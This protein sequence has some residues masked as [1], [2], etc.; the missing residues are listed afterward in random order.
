MAES[1][2]KEKSVGIIILNYK[3][4]TE[5]EE[6]VKSVLKQE[7]SNYHILIVDNGSDNESYGYLK[8]IYQK[9]TKVS[10]IKARKNYGFAKGNNIGIH[11]IKEKYNS[12]YV[13]LLN[14]DVLLVDPYYIQKMIDSDGTNIGVIGSKIMQ[15][16]ERKRTVL[17]K[18]YRYVS[19]P[20][21][22]IYYGRLIAKCRNAYILLDMIDNILKKC[23]GDYI[24]QGCVLLLTPQY[25]Q[26]YKGLDA[27]TFLYCEE[28]LLFLRCRRV[29]LKEKMVE[30][31]TIL[32]KGKQSSLELYDNCG[33]QFFKYLRVSY[34]YVVLESIRN[35]FHQK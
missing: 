16:G 20:G 11:Y 15:C 35:M 13:L 31:L 7:Y 23:K 3:N 25:F 33:K 30:N 6:C 22:M 29:G 1:R 24:L 34:K 4:Y 18:I 26:Y 28:E 27:R 8:K 2:I 19:F 12:E 21:T 9:E 32:H 10:L 17:K 5:T 14:S